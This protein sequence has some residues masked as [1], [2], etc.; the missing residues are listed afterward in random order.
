MRAMKIIALISY[1]R[2]QHE[3]TLQRITIIRYGLSAGSLEDWLIV[4]AFLDFTS[5]V[6][7]C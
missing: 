7:M 5:L 1:S 6:T 4:E 3:H 2:I